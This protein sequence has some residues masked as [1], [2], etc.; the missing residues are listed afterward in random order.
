MNY[1]EV[2]A[3]FTALLNRDDCTGDQ[4]V[5]FLGLA[6]R[7]VHRELRTPI[8]ERVYVFDVPADGPALD[9]HPLP[10]GFVEA[11]EVV[12]AQVPLAKESLRGLLRRTD[13]QPACYA[14]YGNLLYLRGPVPAGA[15]LELLYYGDFTPLVEDT[16][17]NEL[18]TAAPDLLVYGALSFAGDHFEHDKRGEW[19]ARYQTILASLVEQA[20]SDEMGGGPL[21][22]SPMYPD[23]GT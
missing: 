5:H 20:R 23:P 19:E 2:R 17:T 14:R 12:V 1:A 13:T 7:R 8:T 11:I 18:S 15:A 9:R 22:V 16:D 3:M 21:A 6:T 10:V 4:V